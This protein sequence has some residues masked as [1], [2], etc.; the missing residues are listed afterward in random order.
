[1]LIAICKLPLTTPYNQILLL[2]NEDVMLQSKAKDYER[3]LNEYV[4]KRDANILI[5]DT[6]MVLSASEN[7][8]PITVTKFIV[9]RV[10]G[11]GITCA[12]TVGLNTTTLEID[13]IMVITA[14]LTAVFTN[15]SSADLRIRLLK[16]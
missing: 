2:R 13:D 4:I 11:A 6:E 9:A 5:T 8:G 14:P 16:S 15:T 1:M 7:S 12:L 3:K 10:E